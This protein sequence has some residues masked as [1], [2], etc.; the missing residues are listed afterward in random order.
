MLFRFSALTFNAHR[1]HYDQHY[2]QV[3]EGHPERVVHGPL[4]AILLAELLRARGTNIR[5]FEFRACRPLFV[6]A[7]IHL[8]A[9]AAGDRI[10]LRAL[11]P[12]GMTAMVAEA[13]R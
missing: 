4:T 2:A 3:Q 5:R 10:A 6:D 12:D 9:M 7:A 11:D 13:F 1:I 8:T